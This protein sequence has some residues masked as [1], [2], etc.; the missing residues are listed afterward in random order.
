LTLVIS[1]CYKGNKLREE[2]TL[3]LMYI[4]PNDP[5][6]SNFPY[7]SRKLE[8]PIKDSLKE[9]QFHPDIQSY[10]STKCH[11]R[12]DDSYWVEFFMQYGTRIPPTELYLNNWTNNG[13]ILKFLK[14]LHN[15]TFNLIQFIERNEILSKKSDA[16]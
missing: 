12:E 1:I 2:P 7:K 10:I 14:N 16:F 11:I 3:T 8:S 4:D 5:S 6:D 9:S 15:T 13:E